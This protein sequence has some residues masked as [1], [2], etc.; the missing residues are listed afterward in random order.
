MSN[1]AFKK[2]HLWYL[3]SLLPLSAM[4][5]GIIDIK[6]YISTNVNYD[7]N[8][9]RFS[10]PSEA[11][12]LLGSSETSD[13]AKRID[14]GVNV[15]LRLSRQL[16]GLSANLN[17]TDY[18][19][20]NN[21][22]NTGKSNSLQWDWKLGSKLYGVLSA[23]QTESVAGFNEARTPVKNLR[24][25]DRKTASIN[26]NF[27]PDWTIYVNRVQVEYDNAAVTSR[28]NNRDDEITEGGIRYQSPL[29]TRL[30]LA[31]RINDSTFPGRTGL[32]KI[33]LGDESSQKELIASAEWA[34]T[35]KT[36]IAASLS[37]FNLQS[38]DITNSDRSGFSQRWD[39][40]YRPTEK[41]DLN[42]AVFHTVSPQEDVISTYVKTTGFEFTPNWNLTS[43]VS[44]R[45][46]LA[47]EQI[48]YIG[49][50]SI[51]GNS[52]DRSD[53][54]RLAGLSL[55]YAPTL[56]SLVQLQYQGEKRTSNISNLDYVYNNLNFFFRY[57]F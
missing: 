20:F 13:V 9:Y 11:K 36:K 52:E 47:Y 23:S 48:A 49:S 50:A 29:N 10:S 45:G 55:L 17:K 37:R 30:R 32:V 56:K 15:N 19:R 12:R 54:S 41:I 38:S 1:P 24:A 43:K 42:L 4:A 7:D 51:S 39:F 27:H 53:E 14:V 3:I 57:D 34:P 18:D 22:D 28:I 16:I 25:V 35:F 33:R 46:N 8:V 31:Y 2:V 21:L 6:P 40:G 44:L 5:E 26:W